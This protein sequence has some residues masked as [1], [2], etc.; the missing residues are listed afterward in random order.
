MASTL[1][2]KL[3]YFLLMFLLM[4]TWS[5]QA[6]SRKLDEETIVQKHKLWQTQHGRAYVNEAEEEKRFKIFKDNLEYIEHFNSLGNQTYELGLNQFSDLTN[7]EFVAL[8]TGYKEPPFTGSSEKEIGFL[9]ENLTEVPSSMDWIG[10]GAVTSIK[11]Q[12]IC[13]SCW[14]FSTV[15]AVE[16]INQITTG[17]LISLSEQQLVDC[18]HSNKG[19]RGGW[20]DNAFHYI[21]QN[22][23]ITTEENYPYKGK[24]KKC[25]FKKGAMSTVTIHG[26]ADVPANNEKALLKAVSKQP[27]SVALDSSGFQLYSKGIFSGKCR[28]RLNHAVT[29]VGYGTSE[30]GTKYWLAKNSWGKDWGEKGYI[31][32]KR[33]V[34]APE[35]LCGIAKKASYPIA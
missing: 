8:Y 12:G 5:F 24:D 21:I 19:C 1:T 28:T 35:G 6:M 7:E 25:H 33:E 31:R 18:V 34:D 23:G 17:N 20:M 30:Y 15:A 22:S 2:T 10:A 4:M 16:G 29:I 32:I 9:Y 26:Y 13:G 27:V 14:A 11:D 3:S